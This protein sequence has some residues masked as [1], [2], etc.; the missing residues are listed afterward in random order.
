MQK[1]LIII[2]A[3]M[4]PLLFNAQAVCAEKRPLSFRTESALVEVKVYPFKGPTEGLEPE[5][6]DF[7]YAP[8]RWQACIGLP[9]DPHKS[10]VGS[11]G[12]LYYDYGGGRFYGFGT[13]ILADLETQGLKSK[14]EQSLW[15]PRI[16]IV[17]TEQKIGGLTLRQE[18]WA[19]AP[20]S[21]S[22]SQWSP[23]RVDFLWL[24]V[25]NNSPRSQTGQIVLQIDAKDGFVINDSKTRL[26]KRGNPQKTFCVLSPAC[27]AFSPPDLSKNYVPETGIEV[28]RSPGI[29]KNWAQPNIACDPHFRDVMVGNARPL[30]FKYRAEPKKKYRLAFGLIEGWHA[31]AGVRPLEIRIE[32]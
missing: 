32:G 31:K 16:P 13:R 10:I 11:D 7:R 5:Q 26:F 21:E 22:I 1:R 15:H 19:G 25:T 24:K 2:I 23:R 30:V 3:A 6:L 18:A 8:G 20:Y 12:G 29:S 17:V 9:D 27:S 14:I 28:D 4:F